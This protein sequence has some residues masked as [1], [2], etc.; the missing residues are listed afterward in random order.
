MSGKSTLLRTVGV[1]V[2][3]ALAGALVRAARLHMSPLVIGA[4]LKIED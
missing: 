1:N 4:T 3:L 2:V